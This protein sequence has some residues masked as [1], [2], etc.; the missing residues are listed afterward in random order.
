MNE[1]K[2]EETNLDAKGIGRTA[3][4]RTGGHGSGT[5]RGE[6]EFDF[7]R[8]Y[9]QSFNKS[10]FY[11]K[12]AETALAYLD[13]M[14]PSKEILPQINTL[15]DAQQKD[16]KEALS[17]DM[18][19]WLEMWRSVLGEGKSLPVDIIGMASDLARKD[20]ARLK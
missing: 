13:R 16:I 11:Q 17:A 12:M 1:P 4:T 15:D 14:N 10:L 6:D 5:T 9:R 3:E 8:E 20:R 7:Q 19:E 18:Q 2:K